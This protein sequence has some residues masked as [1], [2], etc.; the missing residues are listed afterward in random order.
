NPVIQKQLLQLE[1]KRKGKDVSNN[2]NILTVMYQK[3]I[4]DHR[5]QLFRCHQYLF[6]KFSINEIH[7][8]T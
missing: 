3:I 7:L 5:K 2:K 1:R 8:L 4:I 6:E